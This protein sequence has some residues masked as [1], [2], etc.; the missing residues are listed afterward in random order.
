MLALLAGCSKKGSSAALYS[1]L[2]ASDLAIG[3]H[4]EMPRAEVEAVLG[5]PDQTKEKQRGLY[6]EAYYI[7]RTPED[8][9]ALPPPIPDLLGPQLKLTYVDGKLAQVYNAYQVDQEKPLLP[10]KVVEPLAGLKVGSRRSDLHKLLGKPLRSGADQDEW[11][12]EGEAAIVDV[13]LK[14][15]HV[16]EAQADLAA[17]LTISSK[18]STTESRGEQ[19]EKNKKARDSMH[20]Q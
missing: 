13:Q 5:A 6:V 2:A 19:F 16:D 20:G 11:R 8:D 9:P 15:L 14:F 3:V 7:T 12:F 17:A 4:F 10:P 18:A 1:A